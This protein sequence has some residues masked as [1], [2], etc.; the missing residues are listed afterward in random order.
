MG[1][2]A[3]LT[4]IHDLLKAQVAAVVAGEHQRVL[5]GAMRHEELLAL[6][7]DAELDLTPEEL[8]PL[9]EQIDRQ[10]TKLTSLLAAEGARTDYLLRLILNKGAA[11]PGG[12][13]SSVQDRAKASR[14]N[15]RT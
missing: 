6:L 15:R 9:I 2:R 14:L 1:A 8:R 13:P 12:Y 10:K 7:Q 11:K 4:E 3:I 5:A